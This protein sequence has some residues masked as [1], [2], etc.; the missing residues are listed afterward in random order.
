MRRI[1]TDDQYASCLDNK[2]IKQ[3]WKFNY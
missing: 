1:I 3:N 2:D